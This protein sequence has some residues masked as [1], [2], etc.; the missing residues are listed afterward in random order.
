MIDSLIRYT[1][2][3][4]CFILFFRVDGFYNKN[5]FP[6]LWKKVEQMIDDG[7][8]ISHKEVYQEIIQGDDDLVIWAKD[9]K[10]TFKDYDLENEPDVIKEIG[11]IDPKFTDQKK[12]GAHADPWLIA[13]AKVNNITI[14]TQENKKGIPRICKDLGINCVN[15]VEFIKKENII[16]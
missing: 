4:N 3:I 6:S 16:T 9:H 14:I 2:D 11:R 8:I 7:I 13:Q 10:K 15:M 12:E 5:L 1:I